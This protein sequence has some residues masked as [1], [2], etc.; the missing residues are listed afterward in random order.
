[1]R[2]YR[3]DQPGGNYH[4]AK[5]QE[6]NLLVPT[7]FSKFSAG[8]LKCAIA[9]GQKTG[10]ARIIICHV[11]QEAAGE[12]TGESIN[13]IADLTSERREALTAS[14]KAVETILKGSA[15]PFE[16]RF[17][18]GGITDFIEKL[19][20]QE[21]IKYIFMGSQ[22]KKKKE[23]GHI[24]SNALETL[25]KVKVPIFIATRD[26]DDLSIDKVVYASNYDQRDKGAF[27][28]IL[29][30]L[31]AYEP[32]IYLLHIDLPKVFH[33][34]KFILRDAMN[35]FKKM[36][37]DFN[38]E[39]SIYK[40]SSVGKGVVDFCEEVDVDIL[41]FSGSGHN[42]F[43]KA[44]IARPSDYFISNCKHP[45]LFVDDTLIEE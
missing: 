5:T 35:D 45:V 6:V 25:S 18:G 37:A 31:N 15:I 20:G 44:R 21:S 11:V 3:F 27:S 8:A 10:G 1:M 39:T 19:V 36:A 30:F 32:K 26:A 12:W 41:A 28:Q 2:T 13:D 40:N 43:G 33:V 7:D 38:T 29:T 16:W 24:G 42:L 17:A 14:I 22:G 9:W 34:T 23:G 4:Y